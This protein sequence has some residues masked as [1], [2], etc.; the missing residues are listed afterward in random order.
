[1]IPSR[2][3][4]IEFALARSP[5]CKQIKYENQ[6]K[7]IQQIPKHFQNANGERCLDLDNDESKTRERI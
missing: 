2:T 1:M 3:L 7:S 5:K 6:T 4:G